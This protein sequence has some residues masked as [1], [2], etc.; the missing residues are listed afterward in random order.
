MLL[1]E[2]VAHVVQF[3]PKFC[4]YEPH[5]SNFHQTLSS[6]AVSLHACRLKGSLDHLTSEEIRTGV[7]PIA[8]ADSNICHVE[9]CILAD[10]CTYT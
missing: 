9:A 1:C 5:C 3:G 7:L 2:V 6:R 8:I 10:M 4:V